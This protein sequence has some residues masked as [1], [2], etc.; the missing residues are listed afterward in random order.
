M[1]FSFSTGLWFLY[2]FFLWGFPK[3]VFI[4]PILS[5]SLYMEIFLSVLPA[6]YLPSL[7]AWHSLTPAE[8][9]THF[10]LSN[11]FFVLDSLYF[12]GMFWDGRFSL[13]PAYT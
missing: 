7:L 3:V 1:G 12:V 5:G 4:I 13:V 10:P 6:R 8:H 11:I 9:F 2:V